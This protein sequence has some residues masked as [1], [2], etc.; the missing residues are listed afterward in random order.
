MVMQ[1]PHLLTIDEGDTAILGTTGNWEPTDETP[2]ATSYPCREE[3]G[4]NQKI[5]LEDGE[6]HSYSSLIYCPLN[7]PTILPGSIVT[8]MQG[9]TVRAKGEVKAFIRD[10]FNCRI[11]L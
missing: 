4:G 10:Q 2:S 8:V 5:A 3:R 9:T 7:T 1:Y 11:W 6:V